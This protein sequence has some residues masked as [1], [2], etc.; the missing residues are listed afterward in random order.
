V[1]EDLYVIHDSI[2][3]RLGPSVLMDLRRNRRPF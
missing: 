1:E 3:D 2:I